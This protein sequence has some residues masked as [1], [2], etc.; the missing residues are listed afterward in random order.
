MVKAI[1]RFISGCITVAIIVLA[2]IIGM[3][4]MTKRV[5]IKSYVN[6]YEAVGD[7][8]YMEM[9]GYDGAELVDNSNVY[10]YL[11]QH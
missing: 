10:V 7:A 6:N 4:F 5:V 1:E 3:L 2:V 8:M 11:K 9:S